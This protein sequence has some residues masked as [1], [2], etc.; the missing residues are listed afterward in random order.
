MPKNKIVVLCFSAL[1]I[2]TV[3]QS[4]SL[5]SSISSNMSYENKTLIVYYGSLISLFILVFIVLSIF[6]L[7]CWKDK[8]ILLHSYNK[9]S[10]SELTF[11]KLEKIAIQLNK[12]PITRG[13]YSNLV[14]ADKILKDIEI[15][16]Y[17]AE[18]PSK[19]EVII[20]IRALKTLYNQ[21]EIELLLKPSDMLKLNNINDFFFTTTLS[22]MS[23]KS[24]LTQNE[25]ESDYHHK[26]LTKKNLQ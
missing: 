7:Y 12:K 23:S 25:M 22:Q 6:Y 21:L 17:Y 16:G 8:N 10:F 9:Y 3:L 13:N 19:L 2:S 14:K 5:I 11:E 26:P 24:H 15:N 18:K 1:T 20:L 4:I